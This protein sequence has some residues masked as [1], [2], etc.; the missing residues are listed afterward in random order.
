MRGIVSLRPVE[1]DDLPILFAHQLDPEA[2]RLAA[3]PSRD[4]EAFML[5]WTTKVLGDPANASRAVLYDGR[6]AGY[7]CAWTDADTHERML[8]YWIGREFW[9]HGIAT[10]A[11]EQ[12]LPTESIRPINAR[13]AKHNLGSIRV[14]EK[15][16]FARVGEEAFTLAD[17][18]SATE[19]VYRREAAREARLSVPRSRAP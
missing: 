5:H 2:T 3:F 6:V 10:A 11:V 4:R 18:T 17:G 13:V 1:A 19:F 7:V 8:G 14:L 12:F 9:G 16:G 15:S